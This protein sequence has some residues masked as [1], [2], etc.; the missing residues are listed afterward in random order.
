VRG[1]VSLDTAFKLPFKLLTAAGIMQ[2]HFL[3]HIS[4]GGRY[5]N[6]LAAF[7]AEM[8]VNTTMIYEHRN[9]TG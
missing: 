4:T 7:I 8:A 2:C 6:R 3:S 9:S 1:V 5:D